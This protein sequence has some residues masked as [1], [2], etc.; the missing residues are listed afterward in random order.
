MVAERQSLIAAP[1]L[2]ALAF[3]GLYLVIALPVLW[4]RPMPWVF[5][6]ASCVL[7]VALAVLSAIDLETQRLPD[8]LTLPLLAVGIVVC[9]VTAAAPIWWRV[10]S[11]LIGFLALFGVAWAYSRIRGRA[12]LGLGDAKLLAASGAWLGAEGLPSVV[13]GGSV[14]ALIG[15]LV[16]MAAGSTVTASSRIPFGPFLA[17]AT[18][19]V[20]LYGPIT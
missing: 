7:C 15:V 1:M 5:I 8:M 14:A 2:S 12:G 10:L 4:V 18:W 3:A 19:L 17:L 16:S 20:W 9:W 6:L 13:L 11:A